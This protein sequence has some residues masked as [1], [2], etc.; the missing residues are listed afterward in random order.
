[1]PKQL[2]KGAIAGILSGIVLGVVLIVL[3]YLFNPL[4]L[5]EGMSLTGTKFAV[6]AI[7]SGI[8]YGVIFGSAY[9]II[10]HSLPHTFRGAYYGL[11][12]WALS[13][14][15]SV[16]DSIIFSRASIMG[17][18]LFLIMTFVAYVVFGLVLEYMYEFA[19][20]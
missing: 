13:G 15:V 9:R 11:F 16:S 8:L 7:V 12:I 2:A 18:T 6:A 14:V 5:I 19:K 20:F 1:M 10:Y 17:S 3:G 4:F